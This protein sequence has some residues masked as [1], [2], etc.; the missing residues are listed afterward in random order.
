MYRVRDGKLQVFLGH[1][2]GPLFA[3]KDDGYW[4]IPKGEPD[5]NEELLEAAKREFEEETGIAPKSQFIPLT[6]V[7]QNLLPWHQPPVRWSWKGQSGR[8]TGSRDR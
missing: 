7:K 1:P 2:G 4:T 8:R 6:P 3:R 5:P